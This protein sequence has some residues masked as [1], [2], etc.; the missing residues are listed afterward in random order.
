MKVFVFTYDRYDSLTT[1]IFLEQSSADYTVLCHSEEAKQQFVQ[2]GR[3]RSDR[4][5]ATGEPKGLANNRNKA[6]DM[7]ER[8]EWALFLVDDWISA[9]EIENLD[10][11]GAQTDLGVQTGQSMADWHKRFSSPVD[12]RLFLRRAE[13]LAHQCDSRNCWLGGFAGNNNPLFRSK[14]WGLNCLAD[15]RAWVIKKSHLRFDT[16]AQLID[17]V[18]FCAENIIRGR[19]VLV[20][21]WVLTECQR[22]TDG[23]YGSIQKRLKQRKAECEYLVNKYPKLVCYAKKAGWEHGS[24]IVLRHLS[25]KTLL[26]LKA[27]YKTLNLL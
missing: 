4:I 3:V 5:I 24:H 12:A 20:D 26:K 10:T 7:M 2:A 27:Q 9:T 14:R 23:G 25:D 8:G 17:D 6:L 16:N 19:G 13:Q 22:Y 11:L 18:A 1:P 21:R 15:G